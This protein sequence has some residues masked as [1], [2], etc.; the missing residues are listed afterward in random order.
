ME[1]IEAAFFN[2]DSDGSDGTE[3]DWQKRRLEWA[4]FKA[5][6]LAYKSVPP[7]VAQQNEDGTW[8]KA[9]P[10]ELPWWDKLLWRIFGKRW[11]RFIEWWDF[12]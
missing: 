1:A 12:R 6:L 2:H 3:A 5:Y 10:L 11:V 7:E 8:S 4:S 9:K